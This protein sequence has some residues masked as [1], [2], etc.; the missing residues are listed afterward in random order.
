MDDEQGLNAGIRGLAAEARRALASHPSP[1][2]LLDYHAGDLSAAERERIQDHLALCPECARAVLDLAAFPGVEPA[3]EE[4]RLAT[5]EVD[6]EWRRFQRAAGVPA[7]PRRAPA[8]SSPRLA[9]ALAAVLL[10]AVV[11]LSLWIGRLRSEVGA[12]SGPKVNV[13]VAD[14]APREQAVERS[15]AGEET[16]RVPP[17]TDRLLVILDLAEAPADPEYRVEIAALGG[18]EIWSRRGLRPSED[19]NFTLEVPR[20]LL[21]PGRYVIRLYGLRGNAWTR[22]AEYGVRIEDG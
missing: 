10:L 1:D 3:R 11:G 12:L 17:W 5:A 6:A 9:Y 8:A 18:R 4:D 22:A 13:L 19:G 20:R 16:V 14:L 21:S 7:M 15:A 2:E